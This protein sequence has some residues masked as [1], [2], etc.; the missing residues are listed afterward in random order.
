MY[1][2]QYTL[3]C[4]LYKIHDTILYIIHYTIIGEKNRFLN[5]PN[6]Y[7]VD[8]QLIHRDGGIIGSQSGSKWL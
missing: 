3:Q 7:I 1:F 8:S 4:I 2:I 6:V 5:R